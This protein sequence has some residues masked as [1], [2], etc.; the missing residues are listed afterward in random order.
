MMN[1]DLL[2]HNESNFGVGFVL[3]DKHCLNTA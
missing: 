2:S 1:F 3:I